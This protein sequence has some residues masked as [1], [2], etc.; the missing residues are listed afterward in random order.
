MTSVSPVLSA[1]Q[2][3]TLA[4]VGEERTAAVGGVL[5]AVGDAGYPF[6]AILEGEV[7]ILDTA[8]DEIVRHGASGFLGELNLMTG[9]TV[10]LTAVVRQ[11]LRY[12]A[13][14]RDV[15]RPLL[16]EDGPLGDV[17]LSAFIARREAL[18]QR[19]GIGVEILGPRSSPA[20]RAMVDYVRRARLPYTW[21]D[22]E[23]DDDPSLAAQVAAI[24]PE[25]LP[26][27][28]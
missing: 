13:V 27:V 2:L 23:H 10:Y 25:E 22:P 5:Y 9:Q 8:G 11:P 21:R 1:S 24:A 14:E 20:T 18:Q 7:A 4:A 28:R 19:Q 17:L 26:L 6:I 3:Q 16:F 15:L 12:I